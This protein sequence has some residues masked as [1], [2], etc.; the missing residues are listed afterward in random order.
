[1]LLSFF[2]ARAPVALLES[3]SGAQHHHRRHRSPFSLRVEGLEAVNR[4]RQVDVSVVVVARL[5][6]PLFQNIAK[7]RVEGSVALVHELP[8][9]CVASAFCS[10]QPMRREAPM[11]DFCEEGRRDLRTLERG[12]LVSRPTKQTPLY[13]SPTKQ[14]AFWFRKASFVIAALL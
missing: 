3:E 8:W 9:R 10:S 2:F 11:S 13:R 1:M 6:D 5:C 12:A 14:G 7:G 4:V